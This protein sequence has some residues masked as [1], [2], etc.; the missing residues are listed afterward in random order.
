MQISA[1]PELQLDIKLK[2]DAWPVDGHTPAKAFVH[3]VI[4]D[5]N[6]NPDSI[7]TT[8][9]YFRALDSRDLIETKAL[10]QEWFPLNY[11]D[12]YFKKILKKQLIALGYFYPL[13]ESTD[14]P[15][16]GSL[17][18]EVMVGLILTRIERNKDEVIEVCQAV[19][20]ERG[21][22][23]SIGQLISC[24]D[25][26]AAYIMTIGVVDEFR[27]FG[28]GTKLLEQTIEQIQ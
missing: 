20:T 23:K 16:S 21:M 27:R 18:S 9:F 19:D 2:S 13:D 7:D 8:K 15:G 26:Y 25:Y 5:F 12:E 1:P 4:M 14:A 24:K 11:S 10:H 3:Q 28:I 17:R 6:L 22:L